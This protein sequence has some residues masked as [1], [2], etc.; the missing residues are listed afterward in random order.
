MRAVRRTSDQQQI[1]MG[2]LV[3]YQSDSSDTYNLIQEENASSNFNKIFSKTKQI[4][5]LAIKSY[6]KNL[7]GR[8]LIYDGFPYKNKSGILQEQ[9]MIVSYNNLEHCFGLPYHKRVQEVGT[10]ERIIYDKFLNIYKSSIEKSNMEHQP[11]PMIQEDICDQQYYDTLLSELEKTPTSSKEF[12]NKLNEITNSLEKAYKVS[13]NSNKTME[14]EDLLYYLK[15]TQA[16]I[17]I[18][19]SN[20]SKRTSKNISENQKLL[21][22]LANIVLEYI[23]NDP[24]HLSILNSTGDI[25]ISKLLRLQMPHLP[26]NLNDLDSQELINSKITL[27]NMKKTIVSTIINEYQKN[28]SIEEL[29][30]YIPNIYKEQNT[31]N[32]DLDFEK[33]LSVVDHNTGIDCSEKSTDA[34]LD[35]IGSLGESSTDSRAEEIRL[36]IAIYDEIKNREDLSN[37]IKENCHFWIKEKFEELAEKE[38]Y[39]NEFL[40]KAS[41]HQMVNEL[42]QEINRYINKEKGYKST[43][44]NPILN[45][46]YSK[47]PKVENFFQQLIKTKEDFYIPLNKKLSNIEVGLREE[48]FK[49]DARN[50]SNQQIYEKY[51]L[52]EVTAHLFES[53]DVQEQ[54]KEDFLNHRTTFNWKKIEQ[55]SEIITNLGNLETWSPIIRRVKE[56][57]T[58][59]GNSKYQKTPY[60]A[61]KTPTFETNDLWLAE[62]PIEPDISHLIYFESTQTTLPS[63][64][65]IPCIEPVHVLAGIK[66]EDDKIIAR[67]TKYSEIEPNYLATINNEQNNI[68]AQVTSGDRFF[69]RL[70]K[71]FNIETTKLAEIHKKRKEEY[72]QQ[73]SRDINNF[74]HFVSNEPTAQSMVDELQ[75]SQKL[76]NNQSE[77]GGE[78]K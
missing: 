1:A 46:I 44:Q 52:I 11:Q 41:Y 20:K 49:N 2:T 26:M 67:V 15:K 38:E 19:S 45:E 76:Q 27:K 6:Y 7:K 60:D 18:K 48:L 42:N 55:K 68:N 17:L 77:K 59:R 37:D 31:E 32:K 4:F 50:M 63:G 57:I 72:D 66:L 64:K 54:L 65:E 12:I 62:L 22:T 61:G 75:H 24:S 25:T 14:Q 69:P 3:Q 35:L 34:L 28:I 51:P 30:K 10:T 9:S 43:K 29:Q 36:I 58:F 71:S 39:Y 8:L 33:F 74:H 70:K 21:Q 16:I 40:K 73:A 47:K 53:Q 78:R 23:S 5:D 13:I 56:N